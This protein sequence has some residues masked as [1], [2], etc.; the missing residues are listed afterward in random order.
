MSLVQGWS[1]FSLRLPIPESESVSLQ[2]FVKMLTKCSKLGDDGV[3]RADFGRLRG[4][5]GIRYQ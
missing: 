1:V 3:D 5:L 2:G 4:W